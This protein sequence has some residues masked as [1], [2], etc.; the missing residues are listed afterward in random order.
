MHKCPTKFICLD[1]KMIFKDEEH[2]RYWEILDDQNLDNK[3][4]LDSF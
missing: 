1:T 2:L 3:S 4:F